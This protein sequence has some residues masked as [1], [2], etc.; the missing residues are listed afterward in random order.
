MP[1]DTLLTL[2]DWRAACAQPGTSLR[3]LLAPVLARRL[4]DDP[5][6]ILRCD[7]A[8]IEA[9]VA[10]L[11]GLRPADLPLYG[12][13]FAVKDNIDVAGLPTT[14]ACPAFSH[15]AERSATVVQRLMD[16]GAV[17]VGKTNLDQFATGLVGTRS[18]YGEVPNT[19][20][21]AYVSGG[22]SSGSASVVA[23]GLVAFALGT[24]TAGSGRVPAGLNN[25]VGL[26]PTPGRVPMAGVLPACRTLDVVSVFALTVADAA[27]VMAVI[28]GADGEPV[29]QR[30]ALRPAWLGR[31]GQPLRVG[32]PAEPRCDAA[33]G[34]DRAFDDAVAQLRTW[35]LEPVAVDMQPLF[36]VARLLYDGPWVA[37]RHAV[38]RGLLDEQPDALDPTV[39][40]IIEAARGHDATGAFLAGYRLAELRQQADALWQHIDVLMVPTTPTCPTCA[41][42]AQEPVLRNSE[43]GRFTNFVNLLGQAAL[44]VPS[45]VPDGGL[46][47]GV[48]FIAPGGSD[49]ALVGL[50]RRWE[51]VRELP[52]GRGLRAARPADVALQAQP[53]SAPTLR[54][55]VVGAHLQGMALHGQLVERG[56]RLAERTT[57]SPNYR[58]FALPGTVPPKP[59]LA[60]VGPDDP[61]PGRAIEVEVYEMP[62]DQVG[63]FLALIPPPLGLGS[64]HLAD[65]RWVKGF[66]CEPAALAGAPDIS[67]FAGWRAYMASR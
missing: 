40:R 16:A 22:S 37:E 23:R 58:L 19:F 48:T 61:S 64:V 51:A 33:L 13:P 12:V 47:F 5:A 31:T 50:G 15:V 65:G 1:H 6:W 20:D 34:Y 9:Q 35:G 24:D 43:L 17:L 21:A 26:K 49:A 67:A 32:V 46:P 30:H 8:F 55:A 44:A 36:D 53:A 39:R 29:F 41:A 25:L 59:G 14:A 28:E 38:V 54:I 52:L 42:V 62:A 56:C 3:R 7:D 60:R 4:A 57:T 45:H 27:Q 2:A 63:G 11:E 10:R 66:I 18:P